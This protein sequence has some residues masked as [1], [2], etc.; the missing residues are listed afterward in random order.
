MVALPGVSSSAVSSVQDFVE[1]MAHRGYKTLTVAKTRSTR[2]RHPP[3]LQPQHQ[4]S[5]LGGLS[6]LGGGGASGDA[7]NNN[8]GS[9]DDHW[10]LLG[11]L[12]IIDP[13]RHDTKSTLEEAMAHGVSVKMITG[14]ALPIAKEVLLMVC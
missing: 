14:D 12:C 3:Q 7:D 13:P 4:P 11:V 5:F 8:G 6:G 9:S 10:E 1:G 2:T